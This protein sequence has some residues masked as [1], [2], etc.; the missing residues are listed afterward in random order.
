MCQ[1][2][3]K[4]VDRLKSLDGNVRGRAVEEQTV[5]VV[6]GDRAA[7]VGEILIVDLQET[8]HCCGEAEFR[9]ID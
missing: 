5:G 2:I 9:M 3:S 1:L 4:G 8:K 7:L 6:F